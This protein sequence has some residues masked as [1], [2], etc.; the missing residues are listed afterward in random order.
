MSFTIEN[1]KKLQN[2]DMEQAAYLTAQGFGRE[3]D[4]HNYQDTKDHLDD[5][6]HLQIVRSA[7]NE[8]VGFA[9]YRRLLWQPGN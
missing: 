4:E 7:E 1:P 9:A 2:K 3:A 6:D 5:A 8:L